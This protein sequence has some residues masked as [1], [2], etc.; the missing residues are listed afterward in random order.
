MISEIDEGA[1]GRIYKIK[2]CK[3]GELFAAKVED[4]DKE[5]LRCEV[6]LFHEAKFI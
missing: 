1:F 5:L 6:M 4:E 2:K 3:T